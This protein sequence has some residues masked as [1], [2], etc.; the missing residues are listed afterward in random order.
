MY[1]KIVEKKI[2]DCFKEIKEIRRA[3]DQYK[4]KPL[5]KEREYFSKYILIYISGILE[6]SYK[7]L[8]SD[9]CLQKSNVYLHNFF[10][11]IIIKKSKNATMDNICEILQNINPDLNK[12]FK[13]ELNK[14][15]QS[16]KIISALKSLNILRN[17]F[18]HGIL[19]EKVY[20]TDIEKYF[21]QA[22]KIVII[23]DKIIYLFDEIQNTD[24]NQE[25]NINS[26]KKHM[27]VLY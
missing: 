20:L 27:K 7:T 22:V 1:N 16:K 15:K 5:D 2:K 3:I 9:Y 14:N 24:S 13:K 10:E 21:T 18:A 4:I 6:I 23:L 8:I 19:S 17:S 25:S 12:L 11:S 26:N